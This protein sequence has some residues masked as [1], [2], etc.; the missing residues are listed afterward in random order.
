MGK[1]S[2]DKTFK[3]YITKPV[4][5]IVID[6]M[7]SSITF[8]LASFIFIV[9]EYDPEVGFFILNNPKNILYPF[10]NGAKFSILNLFAVYENEIN[11]VSEALF[12][13]E[14][15]IL[16]KIGRQFSKL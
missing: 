1:E 3:D 5:L 9:K 8:P 10:T 12:K 13:L 4:L 11:V 6:L 7:P 16:S 14:N 2:P 15:G